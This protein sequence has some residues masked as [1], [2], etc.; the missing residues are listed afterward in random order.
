M[1]SMEVGSYKVGSHAGNSGGHSRY[2][3]IEP[4]PSYSGP[5]DNVVIYFHA[6]R[7]PDVGYQTGNWVVGRLPEADFRDLYVML[8]TEDPVYF[9]WGADTSSQLYWLGLGSDEE[10]LADGPP[11]GSR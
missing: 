7:P 11:N 10:P 5:V 9:F 2:I 3:V 4:K 8:Q 1:P 6:A